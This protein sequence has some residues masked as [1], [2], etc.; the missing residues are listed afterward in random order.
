MEGDSGESE[1]IKNS[2][3]YMKDQMARPSRK[4]GFC[5]YEK[6]DRKRPRETTSGMARNSMVVNFSGVARD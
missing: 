2:L 5:T 1:E 4:D 3:L 6:P